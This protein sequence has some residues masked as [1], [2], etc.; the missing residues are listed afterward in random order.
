MAE[1][2]FFLPRRYVAD[3]QW[4]RAT[5]SGVRDLGF[6]REYG[7]DLQSVLAHP[8][9]VILGEP[10]AG[11]STT[12]RAIIQDALASDDSTHL[13]VFASRK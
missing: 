11:K 1:P 3:E 2:A 10:G 12:V 9:V 4:T 7:T 5:T 8:K 13:P 6:L